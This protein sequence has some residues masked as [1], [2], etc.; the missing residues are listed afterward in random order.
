MNNPI[1]MTD[2]YIRNAEHKEY[3]AEHGHFPCVLCDCFWIWNGDN[4]KQDICIN[5]CLTY[6]KYTETKEVHHV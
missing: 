5:I 2:A 1:T 6:R 3:R 4:G